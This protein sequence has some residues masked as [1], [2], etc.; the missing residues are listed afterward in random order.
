MSNENWSE[1]RATAGALA[2]LTRKFAEAP[3][4]SDKTVQLI[5][6][7]GSATVVIQGSLDGTTWATLTDP[8]GDALSFTAAG[9]NLVAENV[10]Y[11]RPS[12]SGGSSQDIDVYLLV[13]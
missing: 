6:T 4:F 11:I 13:R 12:A 7:F 3:H 9:L 5:G 1:A 10:R 8:Q 2:N